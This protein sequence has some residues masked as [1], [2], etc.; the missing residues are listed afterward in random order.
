MTAGAGVHHPHPRAHAARHPGSLFLGVLPW[1]GHAHT[2]HVPFRPCRAFQLGLADAWDIVY[3]PRRLGQKTGWFHAPTTSA[4]PLPPLPSSWASRV[5]DSTYE[6]R[7]ARTSPGDGGHVMSEIGEAVAGRLDPAQAT[8]LSLLVD[9]EA[10]WENM[11]KAPADDAGA[12]A[13]LR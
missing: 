7:N 4:V 11:R 10:G 6:T 5:I 1:L 2:G 13:L 8:Q 12:D 3:R 9:L